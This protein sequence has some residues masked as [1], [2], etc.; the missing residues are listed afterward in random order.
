MRLFAHIALTIA[1]LIGPAGPA[2]AGGS[3]GL[4]E[5]LVAVKASPKLVAE[6]KA[7]LEQQRSS[8]LALRHV[9]EPSLLRAKL[10]LLGG[11]ER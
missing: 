8:L 1:A 7:E 2:S 11:Q 10:A 5:V 3:L 4:D 6:I 9:L